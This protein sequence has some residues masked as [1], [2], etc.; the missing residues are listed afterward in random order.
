MAGD[1]DENGFLEANEDEEEEPLQVSSQE[2]RRLRAQERQRRL[3]HP[4]EEDLFQEEDRPEQFYPLPPSRSPLTPL[5]TEPPPLRRRIPFTPPPRPRAGASSGTPGIAGTTALS[6]WTSLR[7]HSH[8]LIPVT[9]VAL[10]F[11]LVLFT[12]PTLAGAM[13]FIF[14]A[15]GL[16][17]AALLLYAPNDTFWVVVVVGAFVVFVSVTFF[18][19]FLPIFALILSILTLSLGSVALRERYFPVKEGTVAV[20][21]LFGKHNRT[22][23]PGFNLR[24]PGEKVLGIVETTSIRYDARV[25]PI[26]LATGEQVLLSV[27]VTYQTVPGEEHQAIR[28]TKDWQRTVQQQLQMVVQDEVALLSIE[29]FRPSS[30]ARVYAADDEEEEEQHL[31]PLERI[32]ERLTAA[33]RRKVA[34]RGVAVHEVKI[35]LLDMPHLPGGAAPAPQ[36]SAGHAQPGPVSHPTVALPLMPPEQGQVVEGWLQLPTQDDLRGAP[37]GMAG[38][39]VSLVHPA[40]PPV[41]PPALRG[42]VPSAGLPSEPMPLMSAQALAESYDAVLRHRITDL[43]TIQRI[44]SQFE[45]VAADPEL[46]QQVEFDAEQGAHNLRNHLYHLQQRQQAQMAQQQSDDPP[47]LPGL[48]PPPPLG[49]I[50]E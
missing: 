16:I 20:M 10:F 7:L 30:G 12:H 47:T 42:S 15:I 31:S 17:Q 19:L 32:N 8:W 24:I 33:M 36:V 40:G 50:D 13:I 38:P 5:V 29:D 14:A 34:D 9:M 49:Q 22:L 43:G 46:S 11:F 35:H 23:P 4:P 6:G 18:V 37:Q 39:P 25:P 27:A 3:A 21:G 44:I 28:L 41:M 1:S 2:L 45:A 48:P 26:I